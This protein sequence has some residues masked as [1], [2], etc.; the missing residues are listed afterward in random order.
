MKRIKLTNWNARLGPKILVTV[1]LS[2]TFAYAFAS[3]LISN[4]SSELTKYVGAV[5]KKENTL[6]LK[7]AFHAITPTDL[8]TQNLISVI[9]NSNDEI[10]EVD[11][12]MKAST[13]LLSEITSQLNSNLHD[14]NFLGY[15]IDVPVGLLSQNPIF[16]NVGPKIPIKIELQ[17]VALGNVRTSVKPFGINNCLI[18]V[19]LDIFIRTSILYPFEV[20]EVDSEYS[21]LVASK[22]IT[23]K[24]PNFF[25]GAL[26]RESD[27]IDIPI[28]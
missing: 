19:Y 7:E 6:M 25:G 26:T 8:D 22:I 23:G 16:A 2:I 10:T 28:T 27:T 13:S 21:S 20:L 5:V 11:F 17:D 24:V 9:K 14:Y 4:L 1:L 12:D 3:I 15:R 18:E